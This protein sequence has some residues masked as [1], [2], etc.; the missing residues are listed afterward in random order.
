MFKGSKNVDPEA[1]TSIVASVG[2]PQQR[3][4][5]RR[6][7]GVLGDAAGSLPAAGA[8]ARGRSHGDAPHRRGGVPA[9]ARGGQGRAADARREP[10]VRPAERDHLRPR[11]HHASLQAPDDRQHGRSRGGIDRRRPRLPRDVLRAGERDGDDRRRFR[12]RAGDCSWYGS[13]SSRVPKALKPVPRDIP[14]EPPQTQGASRRRRGGVAAAGGR[15]GLSRHLRRQSRFVSAA[16]HVE[17]PVGRPERAH[18]AR[19]R[20]QEAP[21]ADRVRQRQHHGG[22][23]PVL[24]R[25]RWSSPGRRRRRRSRR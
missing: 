6:R 24:S 4:H 12:S 7:D 14:K 8:L 10:A 9:R 22:S 17:D 1:H 18:S 2:G 23:E 19:T 25:W 13:T 11:V 20:L 3:L 21:C 5:D 16:H 15:G